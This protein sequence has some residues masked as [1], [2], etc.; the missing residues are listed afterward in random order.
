MGWPAIIRGINTVDAVTAEAVE[1]PW[2]TLCT[3]LWQQKHY[4]KQKSY[5]TNNGWIAFF[6]AVILNFRCEK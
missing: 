1:L 2:E 4:H 3:T 5:A 6:N